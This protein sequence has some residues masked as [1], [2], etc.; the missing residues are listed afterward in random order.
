MLFE[1]QLV[2]EYHITVLTDVQ[3]Q[4][5]AISLIKYDVFLRRFLP[6]DLLRYWVYK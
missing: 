5:H 6:I 3:G 4:I 2:K 1:I